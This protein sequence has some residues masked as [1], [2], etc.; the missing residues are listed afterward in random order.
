MQKTLNKVNQL[1][2][3]YDRRLDKIH[4]LIMDKY[5]YGQHKCTSNTSEYN[6]V[7]KKLFKLN[8]QFEFLFNKK[9]SIQCKKK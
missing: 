5:W 6:K 7:I 3:K 8:E 1:I 2:R 9:E 4:K